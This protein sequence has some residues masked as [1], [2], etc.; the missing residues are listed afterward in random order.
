MDT[1]VALATPSS[2]DTRGART[3]TTL[4]EGVCSVEDVSPAPP[5][6][7]APTAVAP[8]LT[9]VRE[10]PPSPKSLCPSIR[11]PSLETELLRELL[12]PPPPLFC[13]APMPLSATTAPPPTLRPLLPCPTPT[14]PSGRVSEGN[15]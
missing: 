3:S 2:A 6:L 4:Q 15:P 1:P 9:T 8:G 7:A 12:L 11:P 10:E 5:A 14:L 13:L